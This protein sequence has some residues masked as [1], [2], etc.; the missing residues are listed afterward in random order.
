MVETI[1]SAI[2][3]LGARDTAGL[4]NEIQ[5]LEQAAARLDTAAQ[6]A[7]SSLDNRF[8]GPDVPMARNSP[9]GIAR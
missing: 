2:R 7:R 9:R 3:K 4:E 8:I 5:A 1:R 6:L